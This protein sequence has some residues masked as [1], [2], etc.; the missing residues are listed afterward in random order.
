MFNRFRVGD[1]FWHSRI[2]YTQNCLKYQKVNTLLMQ[3]TRIFTYELEHL[4]KLLE[5]DAF[6]GEEFVVKMVLYLGHVGGYVDEW[7]QV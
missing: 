3:Q 4:P 6:I 5:V 7:Q 1:Y 2:S